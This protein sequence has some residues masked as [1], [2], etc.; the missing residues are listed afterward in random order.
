MFYNN[1]KMRNNQLLYGSAEKFLDLSIEALI[2]RG[3]K[4]EK[5]LSIPRK[6]KSRRSLWWNSRILWL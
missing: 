2:K 5:T 1:V 6:Q 4:N 3:E